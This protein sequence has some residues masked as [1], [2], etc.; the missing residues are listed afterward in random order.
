V[1]NNYIAYKHNTTPSTSTCECV[2]FR[3][4]SFLCYEFVTLFF[5]NVK[6]VIYLFIFLMFAGLIVMLI[7]SCTKYIYIYIRVFC[8]SIDYY[9]YFEVVSIILF[10]FFSVLHTFGVALYFQNKP[11]RLKTGQNYF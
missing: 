10:Y 8:M 7:E 11:K 5:F 2:I 1:V 6:F 3:Q 4:F 9:E